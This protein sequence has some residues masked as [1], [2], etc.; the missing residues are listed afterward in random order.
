MFLSGLSEYRSLPSVA[1][2]PFRDIFKTIKQPKCDT[3]AVFY[4]G[5]A[6]DFVYPKTGEAIIQVL[7]KAGIEVLFPEEQSCC[8]IP[9]WGSGSFDMAADA[10]ERNIIPL[11]EGNPEYVVV[12]CASCTTALKK[13]WIKILKDQHREDLIPQ[14][15]EVAKRTY[16]FTELVDKLV[17]EKKLI[18]KEG[19]ELHTLTYHDSCHAKRHVGISKEPRD[20]LSAAGYVIKEM[21]EC[22]T[23]CGMGG[24]YT[25]KQPEI[26]MQILKQK[27]KHVEETGAEFVSAECPGCLIQLAGGLDKLGSKIKAV[28]PAELMVDKFK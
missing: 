3:K 18:P 19:V 25:L 6:I 17:K 21:T 8:G 10:A 20:A 4:A 12:S 24:S 1:P 5:C 27:M 16:M 15:K 14:A 7:N 28:H 9:H 26:S 23:C 11:L 2:V 13:E 22:D